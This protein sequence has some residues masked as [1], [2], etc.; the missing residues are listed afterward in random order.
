MN[1]TEY[2]GRAKENIQNGFNKLSSIAGTVWEGLVRFAE[3]NSEPL[4]KNERAIVTSIFGD[5]LDLDKIQTVDES[6]LAY[7]NGEFPMNA[8]ERPFVFGNTIFWS[9]NSNVDSLEIDLNSFTL[10][11]QMEEYLQTLKGQSIL[12]HEAAHV[13]QFQ[14]DGF[15]YI[16]DSVTDNNYDFSVDDLISGN[17]LSDFNVERGAT[18]AEY[19]YIL[20]NLPEEYFAMIDDGSYPSPLR[21]HNFKS[22]V[23][24][25][26]IEITSEEQRDELMELMQKYMDEYNTR[27]VENSVTREAEEMLHETLSAGYDTLQGMAQELDEMVDELNRERQE[28]DLLGFGWEL[29]EGGGETLW[30]GLKGTAKTGW[31]LLEGGYEMGREAAKKVWKF[32]SGENGHD[33]ENEEGALESAWDWLF[34]D[35][36]NDDP[37][38]D[39]NVFTRGWNSLFGENGSDEENEEGYFEQGWDYLFGDRDNDNPDD[40]EG[41]L[42]QGWELLFGDDNNDDPDDDEGLLEGLWNGAGDLLFGDDD[43][44]DEDNDEGLVDKAAKGVKNLWNKIF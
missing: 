32:L 7:V 5:T 26:G 21:L 19:Y 14:H 41:V 40:D 2:L 33:S 38:D 12:V 25:Y 4:S 35:K 27:E 39:D 1:F 13:W 23:H 42:E 22:D 31:E 30:E 37:E 34:G 3:E 36:D 8:G 44:D 43:D 29:L 6:A 15:Y 24:P 17:S 11:E 20:S 16:P 10:P 18:I 9:E 28:G